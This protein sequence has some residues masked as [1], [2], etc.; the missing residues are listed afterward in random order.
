MAS[1]E[2]KVQK[3]IFED[4][5]AK[6]F[7]NLMKTINL[8]IQEVKKKHEENYLKPYFNQIV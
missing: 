1:K 4:L 5:M 7:P 2:M 3:K 6:V 8:E